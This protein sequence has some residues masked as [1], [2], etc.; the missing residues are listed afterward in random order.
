VPA[1]LTNPTSSVNQIDSRV[2]TPYNASWNFGVQKQLGSWFTEAGYSA[3]R[4]VKLPIELQTDQLQPSLFY[5]GSQALR[6]Y[7]QYAGVTYLTLDGN[8]NYQS[9]ETK[10]EHRWKD[11][12]VVSAAYTFS[13]LLDDVDES[14]DS[15][16]R[17]HRQGVQNV[18][19]LK[20]EWGIGGY[21]IPQRFVANFVYTLPFGSGKKFV[22]HTPVVSKLVAGWELSGISEFQV[23]QPLPI[24]QPNNTHGFT[25]SQRPNAIASPYLSSGQSLQQWFNTAAFTVAPAFTLGDSPRFPLHGPG[26]ENWDMAL[27]R[28]FMIME[29]AKLQFRGELY[30]AFNHAN[31]NNPNGNVT[32]PSFGAIGGA[33]AGRVTELV[34]RLF[35]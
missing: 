32:S 19:D 26:L 8:S 35:F 22:T 15:N 1:S 25:E 34:L 20:S 10:L 4:G 13:K 17:A 2:R 33:Q 16:S 6:P 28:N 14:A 21:D 11:D 29:R 31:F 18:Y 3:S 23:G 5:T 24:T 9:L 7:P 12:F 27:Q 30:N